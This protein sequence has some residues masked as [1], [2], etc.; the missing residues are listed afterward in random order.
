MTASAFDYISS[1]ATADELIQFFGMLASLVRN[2]V[3]R[4]AWVAVTEYMPKDAASQLANPTDR[5]VFISAGLGGVPA[6]PPDWEQDQLVT[7]VQPPGTPRV[8]N[9]VLPFTMPVKPISPAGIVVL[10]Q[11]TVKR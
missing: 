5:Q 6:Q 8:V 10:Y 3:Y 7:Y 11:T 9:E 2:G 1:R 4:D